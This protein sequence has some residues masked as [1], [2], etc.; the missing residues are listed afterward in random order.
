MSNLALCNRERDEN[1]IYNE[2]SESDRS[3]SCYYILTLAVTENQRRFGIATKNAAKASRLIKEALDSEAIKL[4]DPAVR[5][6]D[7][8]YLPFW[9]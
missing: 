6:R 5:L 4:H 2:V 7:R 8:S 1:G 3:G 9:A